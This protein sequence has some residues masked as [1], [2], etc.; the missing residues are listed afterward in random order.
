MAAY[1]VVRA[2]RYGP[3]VGVVAGAGGVLL[4]FVLVRGGVRTLAWALALDG[5]AYAASVGANAGAVDGAAPLVAAG[6]LLAGELAAW[7]LDER[8]RIAAEPAVR[9][10][11]A[12]A[13][14]LLVVGGLAAAALAVS[15]AAAPAGRGL[16]W[17][18]VG[19]AA[20][21]SAVA[22]VVAVARRAG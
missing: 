2:H 7:S 18:A 8:G 22:L 12:L 11:R 3:V 14:T 15:V 4:A 1:A 20:A 13:V 6:L 5:A 9:R 19:A 21:V 16:V 10:R 17:T